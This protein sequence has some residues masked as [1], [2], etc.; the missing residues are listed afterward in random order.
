MAASPNNTAKQELL[1]RELNCVQSCYQCTSVVFLL[2]FSSV[3]RTDQFFTW[4]V[5]AFP[6][7][8]S[9][10]SL[11]TTLLHRGAKPA[12]QAGLNEPVKRGRGRPRKKP[13]EP[14]APQYAADAAVALDAELAF[15]ESFGGTSNGSGTEPAGVG[16]GV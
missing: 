16:E 7:V 10:A 9:L 5:S 1:L 3:I 15:I 12:E 2:A 4:M 8:P 6:W 13:A 14:E 11:H